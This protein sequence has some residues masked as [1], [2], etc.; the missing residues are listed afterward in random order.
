MNKACRIDC[1]TAYLLH[2]RPYR[3]TSL[4]I[5]VFSR[6]YG[7]VGLVA[8]GARSA[9]SRWA[10]VLMPF[11]RVIL[12]WQGRGELKTVT[13]AES[14]DAPCWLQ[15]DTLI[16]GLYGNELLLRLL[17]RDD[18]H[19]GLLEH[20]EHLLYALR[21]A[22]SSAQ[23]GLNVL[24]PVLRRFEKYLLQELGYGLL[25]EY[26]ARNGEPVV[27]DRRYVYHPDEGPVLCQQANTSAFIIS[28]S[29]LLALAHDA[30][31]DPL[32][33]REAKQ[34]MRLALRQ[35]LGE[36][37]LHSRRLYHARVPAT[38]P[39]DSIIAD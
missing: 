31:L 25:L 33:R 11:R 1:Q 30:A 19:P 22:Q 28:G 23:G 35:H 14:D 32:G 37:P 16:S 5:D 36:R 39:A 9:R 4:I 6:D 3:N 13:M 17:H 34:L 7:R 24:E 20:Y 8:R 2:S 26:D 15:G 29:T 10:A 21:Q 12:S 27:A 38:F 18:P